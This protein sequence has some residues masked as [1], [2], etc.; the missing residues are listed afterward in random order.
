MAAEAFFLPHPEI[1]PALQTS[2][3]AA[4]ASA[5]A[6]RTDISAARPRCSVINL[7]TKAAKCFAAEPSSIEPRLL[8]WEPLPMKTERGTRTIK[9]SRE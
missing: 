9:P 7:S 4:Q 1:N 2:R 5:N 6:L 8:E 3:P